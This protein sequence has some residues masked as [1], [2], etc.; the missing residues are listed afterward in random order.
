MAVVVAYSYFVQNPVGCD[1]IRN[2]IDCIGLLES[3]EDTT[4][5]FDTV[6]SESIEF[7]LGEL[8]GNLGI[9]HCCHYCRRWVYIP[10]SVGRPYCCKNTC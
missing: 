1:A 4:R 5:V 2:E 9:D 3:I 10:F 6:S 8:H 7:V